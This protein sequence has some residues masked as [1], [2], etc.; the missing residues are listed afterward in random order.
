MKTRIL[1][2]AVSLS[3]MSGAM[4]T[5]FMITQYREAPEVKIPTPLQGDSTDVNKFES[6]RLLNA[7]K[8]LIAEETQNWTTMQTDSTGLVH[9][10][11]AADS[12]T[13]KSYETHISSRNFAKGNLKLTTPARAEIFLNG[14]SILRKTASDSLPTEKTVPV[15]LTPTTDYQILVN[16]LSLPQDSGKDADFSLQFIPD[17]GYENVEIS[18]PLSSRRME[19]EDI[20]L[21]LRTTSTEISPNGKY[22]IVRYAEMFDANNQTGYA[23]LLETAT[24]KVVYPRISSSAKWMPKGAT[25]REVEKY[26]DTYNLVVTDV[27]TGK[28]TVKATGL[29]VGTFTMAPDESYMIY[30]DNVEGKKETGVMRRYSDPDDRI[31]GNRDRDY[32]VK[33]DFSTHLATPISYGGPTTTLYD[34][35]SDSK[36]ILVMSNRE[37]PSQYPF[38]E[39]LILEIDANTFK[40]DTLVNGGAFLNYAVYSPDAKQ[41][42]V[43]GGPDMFDGI[44]LNA[45]QH[46]T[47][48]N[49]DVQGYIYDIPT[50]RAKAM[51]RD[52][53]PSISGKPVWNPATGMIYFRATKG[54]EVPVYSLNPKTGNIKELPCGIATNSNFS[55]GNSE[56][57]WM[58]YVGQTFDNVGEAFLMNLTNEKVEILDNPMQQRLGNIQTGKIEPWVYHHKDGSVIDGIICYPPDFDSTKKYPLIV[59]YYA[60]T[61]PSS[62]TMHHPYNPHLF[63]SRDYVV[64]VPNPSGTIGYGQEFSARHVNAWGKRTAEEII[65]GTKEFCRQHPFVNDKK[66]GCIG[67]SYG[68]FMTQYLQ[69]LTDIFTCAVSHA[70][71]S[72]VT[73]YWGEGFWGYSYNSVAAAK[74]YPWTNPELFTKQGSLFNADKIHTPLLLLHGTE[75][76]NVPIGES[77]QIFNALKVLGRDVEFITVEG[78]NHIITDYEKRKLW[79][80]TIMAWFAKYLQDDPRWW[81]SLY[82]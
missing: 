17:A 51:T 36:K 75:D 8:K 46:E 66:I 20:N 31:P 10:M 22:V 57:K 42:F 64:Y 48:N 6:D 61:T 50:R 24:R 81:D 7:R 52:F 39:A 59:Y 55:I 47:P 1:Y 21:G 29:P 53:D 37:R 35:S 18:S 33:Y 79:H 45:G 26:G 15:T 70:G 32:L 80:A 77:I 67:A 76:T 44:G 78:Q 74:S 62:A 38:Y 41:L 34:I 63:A 69:T 72:N 11:S 40:A 68:G 5:N 25:L 73:S 16:I 28:R 71:I 82:K 13:F 58:S 14:N 4:A 23:T 9:L 49:F 54:F 43:T 65:E 60:G 30:Y 2:C 56:S 3:I 27:A 19:I 12:P